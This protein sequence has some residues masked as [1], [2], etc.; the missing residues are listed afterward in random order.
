MPRSPRA[1]AARH[2]HRWCPSSQL[3]R[4]GRRRSAASPGHRVPPRS[5]SASRGQTSAER[6]A[7]TP[8]RGPPSTRPKSAPGSSAARAASPRR[9]SASTTSS[10]GRITFTS[11][12]SRGAAASRHRPPPARSTEVELSV[13]LWESGVAG[14]ALKAAHR[15]PANIT[16]MS[17]A[18]RTS[19]TRRGALRATGHPL[20]LFFDLVF[21]LALT[22]C[23]ALMADHPLGRRRQGPARARPDGGRGSVRLADQRREPRGGRRPLRDLRRDGSHASSPCACQRRSATRACCSPSPTPASASARSPC[24][25]SPAATSPRCAPRSRPGRRH[26]GRLRPAVVGA[27]FED[28]PP[29]GDLG[30]RAGARHARALP[31]RLRG[32][33]TPATSP[34]A[35]A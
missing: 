30:R 21:V 23:T 15:P 18:A 25:S 34:S 31:V 14:H 26:G 17:T 3:P 11:L 32:L 13:G 8:R 1:S 12:G 22:R 24:S 35:T 2:R 19:P 4:S 10:N 20:E 16:A 29:G 7:R 33:S 6:Q 9:P 5:P 27:L 28:Q